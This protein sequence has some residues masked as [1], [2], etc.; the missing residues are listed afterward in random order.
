MVK[1]ELAIVTC[2][3][4]RCDVIAWIKSVILNEPNNIANNVCKGNR[5]DATHT[6]KQCFARS[7]GEID[8]KLWIIIWKDKRKRKSNTSNQ[9]KSIINQEYV[10][11]RVWQKERENT[12]LKLLAINMCDASNSTCYEEGKRTLQF[13]FQ[14]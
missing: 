13:D 8:A 7:F 2:C 4:F 12:T 11:A 6:H 10:K 3:F 14:N 5:I 1:C 9:W